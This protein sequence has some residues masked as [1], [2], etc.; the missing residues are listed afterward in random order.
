MKIIFLLIFCAVFALANC[1][2]SSVA[3]IYNEG[4]AS[5]ITHTITNKKP[6]D[7]YKIKSNKIES[8]K[9]LAISIN[10]KVDTLISI[11]FVGATM[12]KF[13]YKISN[14]AK[15]SELICNN[16]YLDN[17]YKFRD[18]KL[19]SNQN[20]L[21]IFGVDNA[22]LDNYEFEADIV[23]E[24][25]ISNNNQ[26]SSDISFDKIYTQIIGREFE[27]NFITNQ[28]VSDLEITLNNN[29]QIYKAT[30]FNGGKIRAI[31]PNLDS[32]NYKNLY[33]IAKFKNQKGEK[34]EI[35][36]QIFTARPVEFKLENIPKNL[37]GGE[38]YKDIRLIALD[39]NGVVVAGY[40][41]VFN[42]DYIRH[43]LL[44]CQANISNEIIEFKNGV[45]VI[46]TDNK[47]FIYP[48][49]GVAKI[50]FRDGQNSDKI[51]NLCILNSFDNI[52]DEQGRIGCDAGIFTEIGY[53]D[54]DKITHTKSK[55]ESKFGL[56]G[57]IDG[58]LS[59]KAYDDFMGVVAS[60]E[61][62]AR[63]V[64]DTVAKLFSANC[65]ASDV[66]FSNTSNLIIH[67][68]GEPNDKN[69]IYQSGQN[70]YTMSQNS[71]KNGVGKAFVKLSMP[72]NKPQN[73]L[74]I[75]TNDLDINLT[76][77]SNLTQ[78]TTPNYSYIY[79]AN[80]YGQK[81]AQ[82]DNFPYFAQIYFAI[83]CDSKCQDI[84]KN[85]DE[86]API[87]DKNMSAVDE[88]KDYFVF[89]DF[90]ASNDIVE[91]E[92][93]SNLPSNV[94]NG[95]M[96]IKIDSEQKGEFKIKNPHFIGRDFVWVRLFKDEFWSGVGE[97]GKV[98]GV[99]GNQNIRYNRT[100][101]W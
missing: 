88:L 94:V 55:F 12:A 9:Q 16:T 66:S 36:S 32:L 43:T 18:I 77:R 51:R 69:Y 25:I 59:Q 31:I 17:G 98:M 71:F 49:I 80:A 40:N 45:G 64:D 41:A 28:I 34:K 81:L 63:L 67:A 21:I 96:S 54:Y 93:I 79:Y 42:G 6:K 68:I 5:N 60:I 70:I 92:N 13:D 20:L 11:N 23:I 86:F 74:K 84:A 82:T 1:D 61:L 85:S 62:E 38:R 52:A 72:K 89:K 76:Q 101:E 75:T 24:H 57:T 87:L 35:K 78:N 7:G 100:I 4:I 15:N 65:Y 58:N 33:F 37:K 44:D 30:S 2:I 27:L 83:Y 48:D 19:K 8:N 50:E 39:Y 73:P 99:E 56:F 47:G 95:V 91:F 3:S 29:Y 22:G 53:F 97:Y 10:T 26:I 14:T 46:S 90:N